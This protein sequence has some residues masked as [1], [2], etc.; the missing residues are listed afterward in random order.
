M[1]E[2]AFCR[3]V[4]GNLPAHVVYEDETTI[5]FLDNAPLERGHTLVVPKHHA[6]NLFDIDPDLAAQVTQVVARIAPRLVAAVGADGLNVSQNNERAAGQLVF[7]YHVHLIPRWEV[8]E[9][10][11][12][13][14]GRLSLSREEMEII[15][16]IIRD[17]ISET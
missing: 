15:G 13:H 16:Q 9:H 6:R 7:H 11:P 5:A 2:C 8:R 10:S 14:W 12:R 4:A 1:G 3:I 17:Q